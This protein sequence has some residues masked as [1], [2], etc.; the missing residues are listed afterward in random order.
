MPNKVG[1]IGHFYDGYPHKVFTTLL[2][3]TFAN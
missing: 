1:E 2:L 3:Y